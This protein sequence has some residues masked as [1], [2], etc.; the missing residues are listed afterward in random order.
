LGFT[1]RIIYSLPFLSIIDQNA[2]VFSE[3]LAGIEGISWKDL[4]DMEEEDRSRRLGEIS[5]D[6]ILKH[7]HLADVVYRIKGRRI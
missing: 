7:H 2:E 3:V 5:S 4:F 1:P 6:L